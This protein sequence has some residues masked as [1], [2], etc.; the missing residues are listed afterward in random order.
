MQLEF[1]DAQHLNLAELSLQ[2]FGLLELLPKLSWQVSYSIK[3]HTFCFA[4]QSQSA[5]HVPPAGHTPPI[6]NASPAPMGANAP[7]AAKIKIAPNTKTLAQRKNFRT[8][9]L[10]LKNVSDILIGEMRFL[11]FL[12]YPILRCNAKKLW[13]GYISTKLQVCAF[14]RLPGLGVSSHQNFVRALRSKILCGSCPA[15]RSRFARHRYGF[16]VPTHAKQLACSR[17]TKTHFVRFCA[18]AGTRTQ[19][20]LLRRQVLYPIELQ[21]HCPIYGRLIFIGIEC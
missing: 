5:A 10:V 1:W 20:P 6:A 13:I 21:A 8:C 7:M 15:S 9:V 16:R 2:K 17:R 11:I 18:P 3:P 4:Q 12:L 19:N 14:V